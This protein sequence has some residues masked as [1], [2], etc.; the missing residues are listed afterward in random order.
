MKSNPA[1]PGGSLT[2]KPTWSNP[3]GCSA[4]SAFFSH[5]SSRAPIKAE[6]W[7]ASFPQRHDQ[8]IPNSTS[9]MQVFEHEGMVSRCNPGWRT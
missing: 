7:L 1:G 3:P 6:Q 8:F 9:T 4:T 2:S 5:A